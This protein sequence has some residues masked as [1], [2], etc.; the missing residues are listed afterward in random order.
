MYK[1][2][3]HQRPVTPYWS[4]TFLLLLGIP[5]FTFLLGEKKEIHISEVNSSVSVVNPNKPI[6]RW[7]R[8][9]S[10]E[11]SALNDNDPNTN[12]IDFHTG[13]EA[14][15]NDV[16]VNIS[17]EGAPHAPDG[18]TINNRYS[19]RWGLTSFNNSRESVGESGNKY[20]FKFSEPFPI[21]INSKEHNYFNDGEHI[22]V[23]AWLAGVPVNMFGSLSIPSPPQSMN[24]NGTP[25]IEFHANGHYG[26]GLFWSANSNGNMID[27][28]CVEYYRT[29]SGQNH[30]GRE[31]FTINICDPAANRVLLDDPWALAHPDAILPPVNILDNLILHK[32]T[33]CIEPASSGIAGNV[34]V[35]FRMT[36]TNISTDL[37]TNIQLEDDLR[38]HIPGNALVGFKGVVFDLG[39]NVTTNPTFKPAFD[40]IN[41]IQIFDGISGQIDP[42]Q[43]LVVDLTVEIN[44]NVL[45][46]YD[47]I[48]N[49]SFGYGI[50]PPGHHV[51]AT[52]DAP[53]GSPGDLGDPDI[54]DGLLLFIPSINTS[55]SAKDYD[56][57]PSCETGRDVEVTLVLQIKNTG[58][59]L[60]DEILAILDLSANFGSAF[61]ALVGPPIVAASTFSPTFN[62]N[63]GYTGIS[64]NN[65]VFN[66]PGKAF[67]R[68]DSLT[69]EV[70]VLLDP[71]AAGAL[72]PLLNKATVS[73][74]GLFP[75][76]APIDPHIPLP[77]CIAGELIATDGSDAGLIV[78]SQN[79]GFVGDTGGSDDVHP[80]NL[81]GMGLSKQVL[82]FTPAVSNVAGNLDVT[83]RLVLKNTGNTP[84]V[85][86]ALNDDLM[87][88]LG[89]SFVNVVQQPF[90]VSSNAASNPAIGVFP[91]IFSGVGGNILPNQSI[92]VDFKIEMNPDAGGVSYPL[93]NFAQATANGVAL[94]GGIYPISVISDS[95]PNPESNNAGQP[96]VPGCGGDTLAVNLPAIRLAQ[97]VAGV[98]P[99]TS[100]IIG[101]FDVIFQVLAQN[102]GSVPLTNLSLLE[103]LTSPGQ[104]GSAF[105]AV[106][107]FPQ[108][109]PVGI[110]GTIGN[111]STNPTANPA[112]NGTN[113]LLTG[114]GLLLPGELF[115]LQYRIEVNP[116]APGAPIMMRAQVNGSGTGD[117]PLG[118]PI[119]V[120][121][122]SDSGFVPQSNNQ[123]RPGDTG[124]SDDPTPLTN[125]FNLV[126]GG[127]TCNDDVQVSLNQDC[128]A[129]L[130]P[131]MVLEGEAE[132]CAD[133]DLLPLGTY[134]EIVMVKTL[135]GTLVPDLIP[136]TVNIHEIDGSYVGQTLSVKVREIVN[137]NACWGFIH[138]EDKLGP[139]FICP[140]APIMVGCSQSIPASAV[141]QLI[142]NCDPSPTINFV[143]EQII[144]NNIC[145]GV[146]KI[147]RTY[148]GSDQHGNAAASQCIVEIHFNRGDIV[149][150]K[151]VSWHC[152]QYNSFPG[153]TAPT[154]LHSSITDSDL[155][156][157]SDIDAAINLSNNI[158]QNTGSGT[159]GN[160]GGV[161]GYNILK[162]DEPVTTC[163][164]S[165]KIVRTWTVIDWC[166]GQVIM[167]DP[168]GNDNVQLIKIED[169]TAPLVTK[170]A[171]SVNADQSGSHPFPC[172]S[173]GFL[174][175]PDN[176]TDNCNNGVTIQIITPVGAADYIASDGSLGGFIP[177]P[178][179]PMGV[180]D[181]EYRV[182]DAC[183]NS[184]SITVLL[185]VVDNQIP[186]AVCDAVTEVSLTTNGT[187]TVFAETFD[188]GSNDNCC[189]DHFEVRRMT[190]PCNDNHNDLVFGPTVIFC[191]NDVGAGPQM[192]VFRVFD[193]NNNFNDCMVEVNV[194]DKQNPQ[195]VNCP[196]NQTIDCDT[197]AADFETQLAALNGNQTAQN[198]LL[199]AA[200]GT[201]K[202]IDNC[203][204]TLIKN[205]SRNISQCLEGRM[206]RTWRAV[207]PQNLQSSTCTQ[208]IDIF[209]T[210]DWVVEFPADISITCGDVLPSFG[211]PKIFNESCEMIAIS[212]KD[213]TLTVVP[214]ACFKIVRTWA[215]INWCVV[216]ANVDQEVVELPENALGLSFPACDL[217][218]DGDCDSRTFR[219]S[220]NLTAKPN[221]SMA[222]QQFG[223]DTDP[224]SDP[225]DGYITYQQKMKVE[226]FTDPVFTGGCNVPETAITNVG[227]DAIVMLPTLNGTVTDCSP[228]ITI[229]VAS[230]IPNGGGFGPYNNV[231]PGI[232]NVTYTAKDN[233]NN[234]TTCMTTI[235]VKDVKKP[236]V[237]CKD[238]IILVI[239]D[240]LPPSVDL[241]AADLD[242][243][244]SDNCSN[245][246]FSFS[247]DTTFTDTTFYCHNVGMDSVEVWV[248]DE[249]GNQDFCKTL[250]IIQADTSVC[251]DDPLVAHLG[252]FIDSENGQPVQDVVV[253]LSGQSNSSLVTDLTGVFHFGNLPIGQDLTVTPVKDDDHLNG[254]TTYDLVLITKHILGVEPLNSPYKMIAADA[255]RS[256]TITTFDLVEIRKMILYINDKFPS[257]T[258]WRFVPKDYQFPNLQNPWAQA[259]PEVINVNNLATDQLDAD[260]VAIKTGD[261]NGSAQTNSQSGSE[262]RNTNGALVLQTNN[263]QWKVG[264]TVTVALTTND[265]EAIGFQFTLH[266]DKELLEFVDAQPCLTDAG[267]IGLRFISDGFLTVSWNDFQNTWVAEEPLLQVVFKSL[268]P[269][270]LAKAIQLT[271]KYTPAE[272]YNIYGELLDVQLAIT[273]NPDTGFEL[274][275]NIPNPFS[276]ATIIGFRIAEASPAVLTITD[277]SGRTIYSV[278]GNYEA[279]YNEVQ[280]KHSD[281]PAS[282]ILYYRLDT[283]GHTATKMMI[284]VK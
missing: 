11:R 220:W 178:G 15:G 94:D 177:S 278:V 162:S 98:E 196:A 57:L 161:C 250:V 148:T 193:C 24:G 95:G 252:G 28:V 151:D 48:V 106:R 142:D 187:A 82:T 139:S 199:D 104:L 19:N 89:N 235:E 229:T 180:H 62:I 92:T 87:T 129:S 55:V 46:Q 97:H 34:D 112:Y 156:S 32:E 283:P 144:D 91:N 137:G 7:N 108:I 265:F 1:E 80:L 201:P 205:F 118:T 284:L 149:F 160:T 259:F 83:Y 260:F 114:G 174:P 47:P 60:L 163:G 277:V 120:N 183:G 31:P 231:P 22:H 36:M 100:G 281:L 282:G 122:P 12:I 279:G 233:C 173:R 155:S 253:K 150:P 111:A 117:G 159:V 65:Q 101:R 8:L 210:S 105:V 6:T 143:G 184:T 169:K 172:V 53:S 202:F 116:K 236:T 132:N 241:N 226:D 224:D 185:S 123:G 17:V 84:L 248:T 191:C 67:S 266:F 68:N 75:L 186:A 131:P 110:N 273:D 13:F 275:Q 109:L 208:H 3:H 261:V 66:D 96:S 262:D 272:A 26:V 50:D 216:G 203:S 251:I 158:L 35:T 79:V 39:N 152:Q 239:V 78:E 198:E 204:F 59:T 242:D 81:A 134:Y 190:D 23:K 247:P 166:T 274:F 157:P 30:F 88:M 99:A 52:S 102:I 14:G 37:L 192:V 234:Q 228:V 244:S 146:Y 54:V 41:D 232:Y 153:I 45:G 136:A 222:T 188:D 243:G 135:L 206:T 165:F 257:N 130:T 85:N 230:N 42:L 237:V 76:A 246:V 74:R 268:Q 280:V 21:D 121:D 211:Q 86:I 58:N 44:P 213:D 125:C 212:Y 207:D 133:D 225:W 267:H 194:N 147:Q 189:L 238:G 20:C 245:I 264:E 72:M 138:L 154:A 103:N 64:P 2:K 113:D 124:T 10:A 73:G 63:G 217:D 18:I 115:I 209:H 29:G 70:R 167:T 16:L 40:G 249:F 223:P 43:T 9:T 181:I 176:V 51:T 168:Q 269:G 276:E 61:K 215:I 90:I 164:N 126:S 145:D 119:T 171:F 256:G 127:I 140:S 270:Q 254:V 69:V 182:T 38:D 71:N 4:S 93:T 227:C 27:S 218:G 271:P 255:N 175:P 179:L 25:E 77:G 56:E 240:T 170:A 258:S 263:Q 49:Q 200:F 214:D 221:N 107:G 195:L 219:D 141:P 5:L 128:I 33:W 197:Y